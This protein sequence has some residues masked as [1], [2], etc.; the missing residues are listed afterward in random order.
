M[1][2]PTTVAHGHG[3]DSERH[4]AVDA[5][6]NRLLRALPTEIYGELQPYLVR[7]EL[8]NGQVLW[9]GQAPIETVYFPRTCVLSLIVEL[10]KGTPVEAGTIGRE[11]MAGL[12]IALGADSTAVTAICQIPGEAAAISASDFR[13]LLS[14]FP[15]L[16]R[17]VFRYAQAMIDET[18]QSVACNARHTLDER[19]ARWLTMTRDR[20]ASDSFPL[21]HEFLAYMLGVRRAGVTEAAG[22]L[23]RA[24]LIRYSR[25]RITI[26]DGAGLEA[27]ACEC[28][29][30]G[31]ARIDQLVP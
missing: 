22:A 17:H 14:R 4:G 11:G 30:V 21:T 18:S 10:E 23:K 13:T 16:E 7:T 19:C 8:R 15:A 27:A 5:E 12:A 2:Q 25:G 26:V 3:G 6:Q 29:G 20:V 31:K 1:T 9:K 28:Y 24:G